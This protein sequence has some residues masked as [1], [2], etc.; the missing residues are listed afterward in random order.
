MSLRGPELTDESEE[1]MRRESKSVRPS[2]GKGRNFIRGKSFRGEL[3]RLFLQ[4][5]KNYAGFLRF[6]L[7]MKFSCRRE[8][9]LISRKLH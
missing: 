8:M 9:M 4:P 6:L 5:R 7:F 3:H 2:K 1:R